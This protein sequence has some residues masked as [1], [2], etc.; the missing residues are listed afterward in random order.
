MSFQQVLN[1]LGQR[2]VVDRTRD[3]FVIATTVI[4]QSIQSGSPLTGAPGQPIDENELRP[5]YIGEFI[6][7]WV[8]QTSTDKEYAIYIE[9]GENAFGLF[10][11][12][13]RVG[14][15]HSR[16]LTIASFSDRIIPYAVARAMGRSGEEVY[17]GMSTI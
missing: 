1:Q 4:Q 8:W 10:T 2:A 15:F 9:N 3:A 12:R 16:A 7:D 17:G 14:G 13:S 11:L 6:S 5:S